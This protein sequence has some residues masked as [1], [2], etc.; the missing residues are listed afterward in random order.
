[1][2]DGIIFDL[3]GTLWDSGEAICN[4]W[5][6][7]LSRHPDVKETV[8]AE[9][10]QSCMGLPNEKIGQKLFPD[11]DAGMQKLLMDECCELENIY[12]SENG[13]ILYPGLI[14]ALESLS[15]VFRLYIVSNCQSGYIESFFK[16]HDTGKYFTDIEC[17]GNTGLTK[18]EN[19]ALIIKRNNIK[20]TV[21]VGDTQGDAD[22]A[23]FAGIPFIYASYGFGNVSR[24]DYRAECITDLTKIFI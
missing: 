7:V 3:D 5:Q 18:G 22:S 11:L 14:P 16:A 1:M 13:G 17:C 24:Y 15:S 10:L 9:K 23:E 6:S 20:N 19:I 21:Y 8:T 4:T 12:L 2:Y